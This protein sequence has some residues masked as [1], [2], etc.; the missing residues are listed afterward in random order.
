[1]FIIINTGATD[2]ETQ[3][4]LAI[5][6]DDIDAILDRIAARR[7][8]KRISS[9]RRCIVSGRP[10]AIGLDDEGSIIQINVEE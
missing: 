7:G 6:P 8:V 10:F 4:R 9:A 5:E 1:M 2:M 3:R